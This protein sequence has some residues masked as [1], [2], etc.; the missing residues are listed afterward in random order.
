M[1]LVHIL[2]SVIIGLGVG[3]WSSSFWAGL[4]TYVFWINFLD[5]PAPASRS[6]RPAI[7]TFLLMA[8]GISWLFGGDD[9]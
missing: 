4:F 1:I 2:F 7:L 3:L 8:I 9:E 5:T 6:E